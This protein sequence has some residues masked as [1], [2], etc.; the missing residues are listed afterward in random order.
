[1][2]NRDLVVGIARGWKTLCCILA[3][4]LLLGCDSS[5]NAGPSAN[6]PSPSPTARD[7]KYTIGDK[8]NFAA[9]GNSEPFKVSGWGG[10]EQEQSWTIG[11]V[12]VLAMR[13]PSATEPLMLRIK[14]GAFAKPPE[15]PSQPV[16][17]FA[18]NQKVADWDVRDRA[19]YTAPLSPAILAA[20]GDLLTITLKIP[21][22]ISP[23]ALGTGE[24]P[25]LLGLAT[26][27]ASLTP[28][29]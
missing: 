12:A 18:N 20:G 9:G 21:K 2:K 23:K 6:N 27:E 4:S 17:I 15:V 19:E 26:F 11:P 1:M 29:K 24:D 13:I 10:A 25:R 5:D 7:N 8:I 22:A 14:C 16:E 3:G 28:T